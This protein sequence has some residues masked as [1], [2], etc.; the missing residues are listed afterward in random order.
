MATSENTAF[1]LSTAV[2]PTA[3]RLWPAATGAAILI[4]VVGALA[5]AQGGYFPTAWGWASTPLLLALGVWAICSGRSEI[6]GREIA[7]SGFVLLFVC[8]IGLST[9]WSA[10]PASSVLE[11]ERGLVP[12]A[13]VVA[14]LMLARRSDLD[15]LALVFVATIT[16]VAMYA[17]STRLF[18]DRLGAFDPFAVYRLSDPIGYW[19]GLGIFCV[20]GLLGALAVVTGAT[21]GY[22]RAAAGASTVVLATTLYFTYSRASW[23]ALAIGLAAALLFTPRRIAACATSTALAVPAGLAVLVA[24]RSSA[25][26]HRESVLPDAVDQGRRMAAVVIALALV[27]A[28]VG[29]LLPLVERRLGPRPRLARV[30]GAG[31]WIAVLTVVIVVGVRLGGPVDITTR[32]WHAFERPPEEGST[33]LNAR[34]FSLS[35]NGRADL[36]RAAWEVAENHPVVGAGAGTFERFW[37]ARTDASFRVRDAHGLYIET[38]AE[39]GPI[40]LALL[41]SALALPL[42]AAF[43]ARRSPVVP[44]LLGAYVAFLLHAAVDWDWELTAVTATGLLAGCLLLLAARTR[45]ARTIALPIRTG[46]VALAALAAV[47]GAVGLVGNSALAHGRS[48]VADRDPSRAIEQAD[49]ARRLMP[50]S[51]DPWLVRGEAELLAGDAGSAAE[52]FRE[53][54]DIDPR[55]WRGWHD[56]AVASEGRARMRALRRALALYPQS[57]EI[58]R[59]IA[60]LRSAGR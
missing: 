13:C 17:L 40:G 41:V 31:G 6:G 49:H 60:A 23:V 54:I 57:S 27:A 43:A 2:L 38:L 5:S 19:N 53:A 9:A 32:T 21:A 55:D 28:A 24:S 8:W 33:D 30:A 18:P 34:L 12:L 36:W 45:S 44:G 4:G 3:R 22:A 52:S 7:F 29:V 25:L 47:V 1:R 39:L 14:F 35:G 37:E 46:V 10:V 11:L 56:L 59:T 15:S 26:T 42:T 48:A 20:I 51:P 16:A 58:R 50:W